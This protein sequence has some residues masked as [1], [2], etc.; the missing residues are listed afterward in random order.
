[1][2]FVDGLLGVLGA[3]ELHRGTSEE[4]TKVVVVKLAFDKLANTFEQFLK[5]KLVSEE[6]YCN[7]TYGDLEV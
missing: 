3:L 1:M 5:Y 6:Q 2:I 7:N 4:V